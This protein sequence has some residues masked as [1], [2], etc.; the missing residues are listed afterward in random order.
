[1]RKF[2]TFQQTILLDVV[3]QY[4]VIRT[5]A[6][7]RFRI[8][9]FKELCNKRLIQRIDG[10]IR[11]HRG[12][13]KIELLMRTSNQRLRAKNK[14]CLVDIILEFPRYYL[15]WECNHLQWE[16]RH[17]RYTLAGIQIPNE[18]SNEP[19]SVYFRTSYST[20]QR[21]GFWMCAGICSPR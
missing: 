14:K 12:N 6:S 21:H 7:T 2:W 8:R 13:G 16:D 4:V 5:D 15:H 18:T 11:D 20:A 17:T 1:M 19:L 9:N 3:N 10:P